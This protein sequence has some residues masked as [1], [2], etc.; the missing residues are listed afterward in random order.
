M[1]RFF[2]TLTGLALAATASG[3]CCDWCNWCNPCRPCGSGCGVPS[4]VAPAATYPV[5]SYLPPTVGMVSPTTYY[6]GPVATA[7]AVPVESLPTY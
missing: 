6:N 5:Q 7:A 1:K 2:S 3:C 4:G